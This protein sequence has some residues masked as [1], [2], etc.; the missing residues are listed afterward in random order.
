MIES[1]KNAHVKNVAKLL[2]NSRERKA[3]KC[4]IVEG[5]KMVFEAV[6]HKLA[7]HVYVSES[8]WEVLN[9]E[10]KAFITECQYDVV[11]DNVFS[12][13]SDTVTPQGMVAT[14]K[15]SDYSLE[16]IMTSSNY[17]KDGVERYIILDNLQDPGNLGTILRTAEAAGFNG[18]LMNKGT[19]DAYNPKVVRSTMGAVLRVPFAYFDETTEIIASCRQKGV[20]VMGAALEG[21]DIREV[22]YPDKLAIIIGNESK[23]ISKECIANCDKLVRIPMKGRTESLNASVAAGILMYMS[24]LSY[25]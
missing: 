13:M 15:M 3:Q 21:E 17:E 10:D 23:G 11:K 22:S 12:G 20:S 4:Y 18:I 19:V 24:S 1:F 8:M 5:R 14:V 6:K 9:G 7:I 25:L 16:D 2:K